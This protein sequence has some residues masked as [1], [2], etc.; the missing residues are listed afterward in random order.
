LK[1]LKHQT[2]NFPDAEHLRIG[3]NLAW[4]KLD[5]Y[6]RLFKKTSMYYTALILP[7]AYRWNWFEDIWQNK[8]EWIAGAKSMVQDV[9]LKDDA[10]FDVRL[11]IR[12]SRGSDPSAKRLRYLDSYED[13]LGFDQQLPKSP[14]TNVK[15]DEYEQWQLD[16]KPGDRR[17]RDSIKYWI[18]KQDRYPRLS[19]MA[20]D[21]FT[22][23]AI[24]A[25]Y[26][27]L[28]G[29]WEDGDGGAQ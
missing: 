11:S 21:F 25:E 10:Y 8:P 13:P 5:K 24:S 17:I 1:K 28:I 27:S 9:W 4:E 22:I 23:Q 6:Y 12:G 18:E 7:S 3:V 20:L 14:F 2:S 26:E 29:C 19:K 15:G 16:R